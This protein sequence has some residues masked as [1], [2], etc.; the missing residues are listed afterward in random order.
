MATASQPIGRLQNK[1]AIVTGGT[2]GIGREI[3][4]A[5]AKEGAT[6]VVADLNERSNNSGEGNSLTHQTIEENG[7]K[8]I[9]VQT[10][11]GHKDSVDNL[12]DT[13]VGKFG[14]LDVC[15][16]FLFCH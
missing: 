8:A 14:R 10:D 3:C 13:T 4:I 1:I 15:V 9:F 7:G 6:V 5:Y 11:I 2:S 16:E 12:V